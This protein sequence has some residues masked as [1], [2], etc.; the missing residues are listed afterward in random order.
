MKSARKTEWSWWGEE[1]KCEGEARE[2][3]ITR[4]MNEEREGETESERGRE[5]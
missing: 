4:N 1:S 2:T 3:Y 5:R